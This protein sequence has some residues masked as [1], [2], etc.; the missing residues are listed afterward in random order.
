MRRIGLAEASVTL[1]NVET[2]FAGGSGE[3]SH[4]GEYN[5][6]QQPFQPYVTYAESEIPV[7]SIDTLLEEWRN[8]K[9]EVHTLPATT[10]VQM[11]DEIA[12]IC[13]QL[14][15]TKFLDFTMTNLVGFNLG[16]FPNLNTL[17]DIVY[18]MV[19]AYQLSL[20]LDK[21]GWFWMNFDKTSIRDCVTEKV[22]AAVLLSRRWILGIGVNLVT[23][24]GSFQ[25]QSSVLEIQMEGLLRFAECLQWPYLRE[26]RNYAEIVRNAA[27]QRLQSAAA[28]PY[29]WDWL[30][31]LTLPGSYYAHKIMIALVLASQSTQKLGLAPTRSFGLVLK[32]RSYW[33]QS[34]VLGRVMA[35]SEDAKAISGWIGPCPAPKNKLVKAWARIPVPIFSFPKSEYSSE[36]VENLAPDQG[37]LDPQPDENPTKYLED[38]EDWS[39]QI[40]PEPPAASKVT[41]NLLSINLEELPTAPEL[42]IQAGRDYKASVEFEVSGQTVV[43]TLKKTPTFVATPPCLEGPHTIHSRQLPDYSN[44]WEISDLKTAPQ[45]ATQNTVM[46]IN[47]TCGDGEV[48]ARAWCVERGTHAVIRR[49]SV[50]PTCFTCAVR[51]ASNVSLGINVLIWSSVSMNPMSM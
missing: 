43:Y 37:L 7:Y 8:L 6:A 34:C 35:G 29:M 24:D 51:M 14:N 21:A 3:T 12:D 22:I 25:L 33:R 41:T 4:L 9:M 26:L 20:R 32:D 31:G 46:V 44:F 19:L 2:V 47:A 1:H 38:L 30:Y 36:G 18:E 45:P 10:S 11:R 23:K 16:V 50:T 40:V 15:S 49:N 39:K 17:T 5:Q 42:V 13:C 28:N 27:P 48:L